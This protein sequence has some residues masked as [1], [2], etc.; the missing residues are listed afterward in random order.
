ML[1]RGARLSAPILCGHTHPLPPPLPQ[2][3]VQVLGCDQWAHD[4][5]AAPRAAHLL[6]GLYLPPW[7]ARQA[8]RG[9]GWMWGGVVGWGWWGRGGE[10]AVVEGG[11]GWTP[12]APPCFKR[13]PN[14]STP[15]MP[16]RPPPT[17]TNTQ[18]PRAWAPWSNAR[19]PTAPTPPTPTRHAW[20]AWGSMP[21]PPPH[22][23]T[24]LVPVVL[25]SRKHMLA[26]P[27]FPCSPSPPHAPPPQTHTHPPLP[28]P[29]APPH[30]PTGHPG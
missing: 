25:P 4:R 27:P 22:T 18:R 5:G 23:H 24:L 2:R 11:Q 15:R 10:R 26:P 19:C 1:G 29:L 9:G 13:S 3:R 16:P 28:P 14:P 17:H 20:G 8:D 12:P 30:T 7:R 6:R 21:P